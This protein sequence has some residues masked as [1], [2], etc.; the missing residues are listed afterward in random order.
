MSAVAPPHRSAIASKAAQSAVNRRCP[1]RPG[2]RATRMSQGRPDNDSTSC[3][4]V[5]PNGSKVRS[6]AKRG[7]YF[8]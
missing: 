5:R 6:T 7:F 8:L 3:M 1:P 2:Q 4:D